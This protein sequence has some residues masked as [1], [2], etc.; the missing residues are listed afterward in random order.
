MWAG[1]NKSVMTKSC[2]PCFC[3]IAVPVSGS[4][5]R[6]PDCPDFIPSFLCPTGL[7]DFSWHNAPKRGEIYQTTRNLTSYL[8]IYQIVIM[9]SK[10][11]LN[12]PTFSIQIPSKIYPNWDFWYEN[13]PSGN[14]DRRRLRHVK[15]I[16]LRQSHKLMQPINMNET[17][18]SN[19]G[20]GGHQNVSYVIRHLCHLG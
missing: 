12:I 15:C 7:P 17:F 9:H 2:G 10:W 1:S 18:T 8:N 14:P 5:L 19:V 11:A 13:I 20:F 16:P 3:A 4:R 6:H